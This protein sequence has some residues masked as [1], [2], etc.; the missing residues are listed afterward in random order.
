MPTPR[1][2][3]GRPYEHQPMPVDFA[4]DEPTNSTL[5]QDYEQFHAPVKARKPKPLLS[6]LLHAWK[7]LVRRIKTRH[8]PDPFKGQA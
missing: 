2:R 7:R 3:A 8:I 5:E 4:G 6:A 1:A